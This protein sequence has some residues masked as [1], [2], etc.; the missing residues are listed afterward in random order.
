METPITP[1]TDYSHDALIARIKNKLKRKPSKYFPGKL[2]PNVT[3]KYLNYLFADRNILAM[4]N[5]LLSPALDNRDIDILSYFLKFPDKQIQTIVIDALIYKEDPYLVDAV[6]DTLTPE[7]KTRLV[8]NVDIST[9]IALPRGDDNCNEDLINSYF[10]TGRV[11]DPEI[12]RLILNAKASHC[13]NLL[14]AVISNLRKL[15]NPRYR[16]VVRT[17]TKKGKVI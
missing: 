14:G 8:R 12:E 3:D 7:D 16:E 11:S 2:G 1:L 6:L 5:F 17:Y 9:L 10:N 13:Q 4:K 15:D